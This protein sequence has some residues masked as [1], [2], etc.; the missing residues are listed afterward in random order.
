VT[1]NVPE[2]VIEPQA[3]IDVPVEDT[4]VTVAAAVREGSA[5]LAAV[6]RYVPAASGAVYRPLE[7]TDPESADHETAV[8]AEP[9]TVAVKRWVVPGA[10]VTCAG[11]IAIEI[12][13]FAANE[14]CAERSAVN[15]T[16]QVGPVQAPVHPEN[17]APALAIAV[18]STFAPSSKLAAHVPGQAMPGGVEVTLPL[19]VT[20][21]VS[22]CFPGAAIGEN[23]APTV[24]SAER[25]R[26]HAPAP[27][28]APDHPLNRAPAS[29]AASR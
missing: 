28:H 19:P 11:E 1:E 6:T 4:T 16:E 17:S 12:P 29:G 5:W 23:A 3:A 25:T 21:T 27:E 22:V 20:A 7:S 15:V 13:A 8:S 2:L 14:A 24:A 26:S 9:E 10:S 18:S